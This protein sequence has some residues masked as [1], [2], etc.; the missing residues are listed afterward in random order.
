[1]SSGADLCQFCPIVSSG[2]QINIQNFVK[3]SV[4]SKIFDLSAISFP[5]TFLLS[6][7]LQVNSTSLIYRPSS[8]NNNIIIIIINGN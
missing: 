1:M 2:N 7:N 5:S 4:L 3:S 8:I 6:N